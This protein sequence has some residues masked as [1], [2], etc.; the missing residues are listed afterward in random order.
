MDAVRAADGRRHLVLEGPALDG[1]QQLVQIVA[2]AGRV[3]RASCTLKAGVEH[4]RGGHALVDEA[5][6]GAD[7]LGEMG[8][9]GDDVVLHLAL[10]GVDPL[11]VEGRLGALL[12]DRSGRLLRH[13]AE[14]GQRRGGMGLDLEPDAELGLGRPD[15]DH[16][17]A[18]VTGDHER[19]TS[20]RGYA[21]RGSMS[22]CDLNAPFAAASRMA[23]M[24]GS[25]SRGAALE[26][27]G[28]RHE[29]VGAGFG[30]QR[31]GLGRHAAVDLDVDVAVADHR[32]DP[33]QLV[34]DGGDEG[35]AAEA[36]IDRHQEDQVD[37]VDAP[38]R[39][40][41]SWVPGLSTMPAFLPSF[42]MVWS[43]R[44]RC[45]PASAWM[46]MMS[47]PALAKASR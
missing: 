3:A 9:E 37:V 34:A 17:G 22:A 4:V 12:P 47:A 15:G 41:P 10:D 11:D 42:R 31:R 43:E 18:A 5:R 35:L 36:G 39:W 13:D 33:A 6:L 16:L 26:R 28:A 20:T 44:C 29:H 46:L 38:A 45:G 1:G 23:A 24:F 19:Y 21:P 8:E 14:I 32:L 7:D 2:A 40:Q 27:G 30:H 25:V